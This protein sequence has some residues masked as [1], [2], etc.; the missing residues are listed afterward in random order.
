M[1]A[2]ATLAGLAI[3][4]MALISC[5]TESEQAGSS[6]TADP[7]VTSAPVDEPGGGSPPELA[8]PVRVTEGD[9]VPPALEDAAYER[10][11]ELAAAAGEGETVAVNGFTV[12]TPQD[13]VPNFPCETDIETVEG[14]SPVEAGYLPP[15]TYE[16]QKPS[17]STCPNG[18]IWITGHLYRVSLEYGPRDAVGAVISVAYFDRTRQ[19]DVSRLDIQEIESG[20]VNGYD[21]V[22]IK[23]ITEEGYGRAAILFGTDDAEIGFYSVITSNLPFEE[24]L[25]IAEGLSCSEC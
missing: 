14:V 13:F 23:P 18:D 5:R 24:T 3:V 7:E 2:L 25:K 10:G 16:T 1:K 8:E 19:L 12:T 21:A 22:F 20:T 6:P 17:I 4:M 15:N 11:V 9:W